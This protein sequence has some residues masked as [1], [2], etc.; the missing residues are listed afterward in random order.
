MRREARAL[1][2]ALTPLIASCHVL[3]RHREF[4][5]G[6]LIHQPMLV[7]A[8]P[9]PYGL[10]PT[11]PASRLF[12]CVASVRRVAPA[13]EVSYRVDIGRSGEVTHL[14]VDRD[15][16]PSLTSCIDRVTRTWTL[17][18]ARTCSGHPVPASFS[19]HVMWSAAGAG[20]HYPGGRLS[21]YMACAPPGDP[22][23]PPPPPGGESGSR[24]LPMPSV[25]CP[26]PPLEPPSR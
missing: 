1:L 15:A 4:A 7:T 3:A 20:V 5:C 26:L 10:P 22:G 18:P 6:D 25:D 9:G 11:D 2:F 19:G 13:R 14:A 17:R 23:P 8:T 16:P 21:A 12:E 24:V